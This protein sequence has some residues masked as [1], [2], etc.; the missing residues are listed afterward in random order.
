MIKRYLINLLVAIDQGINAI[1]A[2]DPDETLSSRAGKRIKTCNLCRMLCLLLDKID[3]RH[4][5]ESIE[6]DEGSNAALKD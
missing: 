1:L 4:C 5:Q 6:P 3:Y 2:G